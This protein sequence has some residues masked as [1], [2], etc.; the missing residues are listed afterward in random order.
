[1]KSAMAERE[2][3]DAQA[4]R[5]LLQEGIRRFPAFWKLHVMLGQLEERLGEEG[6]GRGCW[7]RSRRQG[8]A[9]A[10]QQLSSPVVLQGA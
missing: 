7:R 1:M 8:I 9:A 2:A 5:T 4:E 6:S 3:G 10:C